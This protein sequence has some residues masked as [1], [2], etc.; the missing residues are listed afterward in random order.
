MITG[1]PVE[2]PVN[3][4]DLLQIIYTSGTESRPNGPRRLWCVMA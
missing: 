4:R 1:D 2:D 3:P